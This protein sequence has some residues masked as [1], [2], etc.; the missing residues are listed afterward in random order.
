MPDPVMPGCVAPEWPAA[1]RVR[2]FTTTR[3]GGVSEGAWASLNLGGHCGDRPDHV[4]ENRR[5]LRAWLPAEPRWLRQVHGSGVVQVP[6]SGEEP[7]EADAAWSR[8]PGQVCAVLTADCLPVLLCDRGGNVVAAAHAGWRGLRAGVLC[9]AV[10]AMDVPPG[11]I[12]AWLGPGIGAAAYEVG[13][14]VRNA[15]IETDASLGGAFTPS[16]DR[17]LADLYAIATRQLHTAGVA[18]VHGGGFCTFTDEERFFSYRRDGG[19]GRMAT[20]IWRMA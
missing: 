4:A 16:G 11:E 5:R 3:E 15:F 12:I 7:P 8:T 6:G 9:N 18:S 1:S 14:E 13:G 19:G 17:W 10:R 20:V 2:A